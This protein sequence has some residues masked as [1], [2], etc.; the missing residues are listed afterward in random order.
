MSDLDKKI[1]DIVERLDFF[2][3][4][5]AREKKEIADL[6]AHFRIFQA[7]ESIIEEGSKGTSMFI[8]LSGGVEVSKGD[9]TD[10]LIQLKPGDIFGEI[11]F[12]T[13][14]YRTANIIAADVVIVLEL[15]KQL[16]FEMN[17]H[18]REKLKDKIIEKLI[19]SLEYMN[20]ILFKL[21]LDIEPEPKPEQKSVEP[22]PARDEKAEEIQ[23]EP[24]APLEQVSGAVQSVSKTKGQRLKHDIV[25]NIKSLPPIPNI[26]L[27]AQKLLADPPAGPHDLAQVL[28]SD[29][30]IVAR[31]LKVANSAYYGFRGKVSSIE[32]ASSLFGTKRLG[33]LITTMSIS[34]LLEKNL[35]GY[36]M[37]S[38][39]LWQ[40]A[41]ATA[42]GAKRI[43]EA[44]FPDMA[45]DAYIAGLLHDS[46]KI[47]L[48]ACVLDRKA[49]FTQYMKETGD[50]FLEA[51]RE[52]LGFDH[53]DIASA[54]CSQWAIPELIATAICY[55][56]NPSHPKSNI[57]A[58]LTHYANHLAIKTRIGAYKHSMALKLDQTTGKIMEINETDFDAIVKTVKKD[59]TKTAQRVRSA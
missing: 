40:H 15:D 19:Q 16:L 41:L 36:E 26:L 14:S 50:T 52:I 18:I 1:L 8:L 21:E 17:I 46:G 4:F 43:A 25:K 24:E 44:A 34:G 22:Q 13:N 11:A 39:D 9:N 3:S 31:I 37:K 57:L 2:N 33:E 6:H 10:L 47:I 48:D 5:T 58:H 28:A 12:L 49:A 7:G 38:G 51:E 55:H 59:V 45:E 23:K 54:V 27:K 20:N 42:Y 56:H 35:R 30:A 53:A 29:Q 32:R